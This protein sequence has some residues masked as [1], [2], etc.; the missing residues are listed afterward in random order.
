MRKKMLVLGNGLFVGLIA[1]ALLLL[2]E[3]MFAHTDQTAAQTLRDVVSSEQA[4]AGTIITSDITADTTWTSANSPYTLTANVEVVAGVTLTVEPGVEVRAGHV[5]L[6]VRGTLKAIGTASHPITFT[7][8]SPTSGSWWGISIHGT[9]E[10]PNAG[11]ILDY[12]TIEYGGD[13]LLY[14]LYLDWAEATLSHSTLRHSSRDGLYAAHSTARISD[15]SFISN[16]GYAALFE[17]AKDD[18]DLG[19]LATSGNGHDGI[20]LKRTTLEGDHT[21]ENSGVPYL[22]S[23]VVGVHGVNTAAGSTLT[24]EPG[25]EIQ[26][27]GIGFY[28]EGTLKA[29]GTASQPITFTATSPISGSWDGLHIRGT[30]AN[31]NKGSVLEHVTIEYG[32][33]YK[34]ANLHLR[35]AEAAISHSTLRHSVSTGPFPVHGIYGIYSTAYIS[36]TQFI[37]N[38]DYAAYFGHLQGD[39]ILDSLT[40]SD[41]GYDGIALVHSKLVGDHT[42]ENSGVPYF[43]LGQVDVETGGSLTVDPG[44]EVRA[45]GNPVDVGGPLKAIGTA[46]QPITFTAINPTPGSWGGIRIYGTKENPNEGSVFHH[47]TIEYA[48]WSGNLRLSYANAAISHSALRYSSA[49]G[50]EAQYADG[51]FIERSQIVGNAGYGI[52][53]LSPD[54][55]IGAAHNWWGD[56]SGPAHATCNPGGTGDRVSDGVE[57]LPFLTGPDQEPDPVAPSDA[58][59]LTMKPRRWFAPAD[60]ITRIW[61]EIT[62]RDGNGQ[63]LPGRTVNLNSTLGNVVDGGVTDIQGQTF[64]YVTSNTPGDAELIA[65]LDRETTCEWATSP[66]A[67]VTFT[68]DV[69]DPL[70]ADAEAPYMNSGIE[71]AP[72]PLVAGVPVNVRVDLVNPNAFPIEVDVAF[73]VMQ[74]GIGLTF[75]PIGQVLDR[76]IEANSSAVVG[77]PWT[78]YVSGHVCIQ[79]QYSASEV[80]RAGA[81]RI[82][83]DWFGSGQSQ[84]NSN[85]LPSWLN[86]YDEH[87]TIDD[88][89][90][91]LADVGYGQTTLGL[92]TSPGET[93]FG[94]VTPD[95]GDLVGYIV[96]NNLNLWEKAGLAI[97][98]AGTDQGPYQRFRYRNAVEGHAGGMTPQ[99]SGQPRQDYTTYAMLEALTFTSMEPGGALSPERVDAANAWVD[100]SLDLSAE[101]RAAVISLERYGG[102]A[103]AGD[104]LWASQQAAAYL[105][106]K[107][108]AAGTMLEV[109]D[110]VEA[111]LQVLHNEG[112]DQAIL[113]E[114]TYQDYQERL[115]TEGFDDTEIEAARLLRLTDEEI[116]AV[117][118]ERTNA[119]L[120]EM[121]G[122]VIPAMADTAEFLRAWS[123]AITTTQHFSTSTVAVASL[124]GDNN[125]A[126]ISETASSFLVGNPLSQTATVEL[127]IRRLDMPSDW[128]VTVTPVMATL[129]P[130]EQVTATVTIR[131]GP[132]V[133]QGTQPRVAIEGYISDTLIG[134]VVLDVMVPEAAF[135]DGKL[136]IYLPLALRSP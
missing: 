23:G 100:V 22:L 33:Q 121:V 9:E 92:V 60:G 81:D 124:S 105:Y 45:T 84:R 8:T 13:H 59:L 102:A 109:A 21:W 136:R 47:V 87:T 52:E 103:A 129:A 56:A 24:V 77:V 58:R 15:T 118:Q 88:G 7:A 80:G 2:T 79:V 94:L 35:W 98:Y 131:P 95:A 39:C 112:I 86:S 106:Y 3:L 113:L 28:V 65:Q 6:D 114:E 10:N 36:D 110:R 73:G 123:H 12:V 68:D 62:L 18:L 50:L 91:I 99:F 82:A 55:L 134:G 54:K 40:A 133:V 11:S 90:E 78:P 85:V 20:A 127:R 44:G 117:R 130:G 115:R 126:R 119:D 32:G 125:L 38:H 17:Y 26:S 135:F 25:V 111:F 46:S 42:W 43:L 101:L 66:S 70:F 34:S 67:E 1:C 4:P 128:A 107:Q 83:Q 51:T 61:V 29:I 108:K 19:S 89:R 63:P 14:N 120:A 96:D 41:N 69:A 5:G 116:E 104:Q 31:P 16:N 57:F 72:M 75:G 97:K 122:D 71:I 76:R 30:E 53:N 49:D 64:A 27:D 48:G 37:D 93:V 74:S 132:R